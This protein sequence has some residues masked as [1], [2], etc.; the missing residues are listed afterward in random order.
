MPNPDLAAFLEH[1]RAKGMDHGTIRMLLLSAGW[2]EKDVAQALAEHALDLPVPA[3]PDAGG[4]R[5]AFLHLVLFAALYATAISGVSLLFDYINQM[6]PDPAM[7]E[8]ATANAWHLRSMR[9]SLATVIVAFPVFV[10]LS[11]FVLREMSSA[12]EKTW[13]GVRR[14]LTYL[15]LFA[16]AVALAT[17]FV[18]LVFYLLEGEMSVRFV[19]KV[20][21][22]C[23]VA[24][25]AFVYYLATVRMP[26]RVLAASTMH[27]RFGLAITALVV[28]AFVLGFIVVGLP[29]TERQRKLDERRRDDLAG[30]DGTIERIC[31]GP[32]AS[33]P[34]GPPRELV[35]PLPPDLPA[36]VAGAVEARPTIVDPATG[37]PYEYRITAAST[38]ELCAMFDHARNE[39]YL[40]RWNH[41]AGRHCFAFDV[42]KPD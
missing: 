37:V 22:V 4:A 9:W 11:R 30:I 12:H 33:R 5:E 34:E 18:T 38:F 21:I 26:A 19:L 1:A 42:L 3:P 36:V 24:G 41:P 27:R 29:S 16:A 40:A 35:N 15:T 28:V 14:W 2:K 6:L 23:L 25:M 8:P 39:D 10:W 20:A 17:D 32:P 13:S 31:L 7:S